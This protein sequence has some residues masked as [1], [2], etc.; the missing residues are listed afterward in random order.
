MKGIRNLSAIKSKL[1]SNSI[2]DVRVEK[3][4]KISLNGDYATLQYE[5]IGDNTYDLIHT[6]IPE[7]YQ[8]YGLGTLFANKI[9]EYL[10]NKNAK[11]KL[12]CEFLEKVFNE[13]GDKYR[14]FV[15]PK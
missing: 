6:N 15:I 5:K 9:F 12:T 1:I 7:Q 2:E 4:L 13:S 10:S 8:G 14:N 11:F 3:V